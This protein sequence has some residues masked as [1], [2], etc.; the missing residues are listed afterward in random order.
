VQWS[1]WITSVG[2]GIVCMRGFLLVTRV[3]VLMLSSFTE[4]N[5]YCTVVSFVGLQYTVYKKGLNDSQLSLHAN[6]CSAVLSRFPWLHTLLAKYS[7]KE[8]LY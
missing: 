6:M 1:F 4:N 7:L 5:N 2:G 3:R 8:L